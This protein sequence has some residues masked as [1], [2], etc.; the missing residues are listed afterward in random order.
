MVRA[1]ALMLALATASIANA[2]TDLSGEGSD[3][4]ARANPTGRDLYIG[5]SLYLK[6]TMIAPS[7]SGMS[8]PHSA[9][10]C[11]GV[12]ILALVQREGAKGNDKYRF[13]LPKTADV[14]SD[15]T[16]AFAAA[17]VDFFE[18]TGTRLADTDGLAAMVLAAIDKWP[19][20]TTSG[21]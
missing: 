8:F 15:P 13:C 12:G 2:A 18:K 1:A 11:A 19:C 16:S 9:E 4:Q 21:R 6:K 5:C 7:A 20:P 3:I 14:R 17:Y 10:R